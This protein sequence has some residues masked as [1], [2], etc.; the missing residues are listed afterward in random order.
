MDCNGLELAGVLPNE[1]PLAL[2]SSDQSFEAFF[3][4]QL[5]H[6]ILPSRHQLRRANGKSVD[7]NS[8]YQPVEIE[9]L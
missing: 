4:A 8:N 9:L 1:W 3:G 6:V 2:V 7:W 5:N